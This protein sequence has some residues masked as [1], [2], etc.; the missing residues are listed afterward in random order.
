MSPIEHVFLQCKAIMIMVIVFGFGSTEIFYKAV[1]EPG[2]P[3]ALTTCVWTAGTFYLVIR[4]SD[5]LEF[6]WSRREFRLLH[7]SGECGCRG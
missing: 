3:G 7:E 4:T 1:I 6:L 2:S 5:L